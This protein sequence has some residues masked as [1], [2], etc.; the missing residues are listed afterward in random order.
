M[1]REQ[2]VAIIKNE[3]LGYYSWFDDI[4]ATSANKIVILQKNG[5]WIVYSTG[6]R[7]EIDS[8]QS[9]GSEDDAL[10]TFIRRLRAM[11]KLMARC[12]L[13]AGENN[14]TSE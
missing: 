4:S 9:F 8:M 1:N 10:A 14:K 7:G 2:T 11:N 5:Q 12:R 6:E 13:I 3:Q